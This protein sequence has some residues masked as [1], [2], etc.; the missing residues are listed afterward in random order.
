MHV[1]IALS[2]RTT[3]VERGPSPGLSSLGYLRSLDSLHGHQR[4][5]FPERYTALLR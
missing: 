5:A 3:L 4:V 1:A 2:C